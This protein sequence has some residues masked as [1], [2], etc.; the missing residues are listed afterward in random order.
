MASYV[1]RNPPK[2]SNVDTYTGSKALAR[3]IVG[4]RA[5]MVYA[6]TAQDE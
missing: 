1:N 6:R 2:N 3:S 5:A 4:D